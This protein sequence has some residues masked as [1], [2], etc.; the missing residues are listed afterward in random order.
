MNT[1]KHRFNCRIISSCLF[2]QF[3][4]LFG[5]IF[6]QTPTPTPQKLHYFVKAKLIINP[7]DGKTTENAVME[8]SSGKIVK[9]DK[10]SNFKIPSDAQIF[11]YSEKFIIPVL[12]DAHAHLYTNLT[13]GHSTNPA[14]PPLFIAGGVTSILAPG[15]GDPEGDIALK[16]RVD[17]GRVVGPRMFLAGEY[18]DMKPLNVPW[19]EAVETELEVKS[20]LDH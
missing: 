1:D 12:I 16:N 19:M 2:L 14:L 13:F 10:A 6:A 3:V 11:D 5:N 4:F 18:I 15:S 7:A 20:K 17:S 8:V 9:I